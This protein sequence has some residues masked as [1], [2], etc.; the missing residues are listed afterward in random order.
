MKKIVLLL[1][2]GFG[3]AASAQELYVFSEPASNMPAHTITPRFTS[4]FGSAPNRP[5]QRYT[6]ELMLGLNRFFMVHG[7]VSFSNLPSGRLRYESAYLY[8]KYRFLSRDDVHRHFRL[9]AF[10]EGSYNRRD[11]LTDEIS[12]Q[13]E[14]SG[15]QL[16]LIATQLLGRMAISATAGHT[17]AL[18]AARFRHY[19]GDP[20]HPYQSVNYSV[21]AGLLVLPFSYTSYRQLNLNLYV[22]LLG[23][24]TLDQK[25][26]Y[27]DLAPA[28]QLLFNS[29]TKLNLGY[30]FQL[31][32]DQLRNMTKTFLVSFEHTLFNMMGKH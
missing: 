14:R 31:K 1:A 2:L 13:G 18:D 9:A 25:T 4:I 12:L 16:G 24:R 29:N 30:R 11:A 17:Q 28:V 6:P 3:L 7:G 26:F 22:E 19:N 21:S 8:G 23:Q 27:N 15:V 20:V 32:G 10:A 5:D